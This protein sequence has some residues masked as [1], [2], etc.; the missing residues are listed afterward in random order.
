MTGREPMRFDTVNLAEAGLRVLGFAPR[1]NQPRQWVALRE[2]GNLFA[3]V[4]DESAI[5]PG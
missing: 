5:A 4:V 2:D 1:P 3:A